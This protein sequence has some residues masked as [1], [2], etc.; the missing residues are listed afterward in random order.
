MPPKVLLYCVVVMRSRFHQRNRLALIF[1]HSPNDCVA[2]ANVPDWPMVAELLPDTGEARSQLQGRYRPSEQT[3]AELM[4]AVL[5][6]LPPGRTVLVLDGV[7]HLLDRSGVF[8]DDCDG[9]EAVL[10]R[11][12]AAA[13][14]DLGQPGGRRA[15][16]DRDSATT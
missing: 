12:T 9:Q 14:Q 1:H 15:C 2:P 8:A 7:D 3:A 4:R 5:D 10:D 13:P 16:R 11:P 6:D